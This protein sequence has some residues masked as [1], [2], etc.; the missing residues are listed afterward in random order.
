M[1]GYNM[2][3]TLENIRTI[4][5]VFL[6]IFLMWLVVYYAIKLVRSNFRTI[7]IFK[8]ILLVIIIDGIAKLLGL[9]TIAYMTDI[10]INWGFLAVII[11]F[12]PEIRSLLERLGKSNVFSRITTLTGNEKEHLVDQIVTAAMLLSQDQTG[13]LI[14]IEQ[15]HSLEDFIA[16]GTRL[17]SDVTAELLTSIFVTSTPLHDGAV[18]IQG[19]KIAC[20][21][22]YFPPTN[23]DL[24]SRYGARH[25]AAIGISEITDAVTIVISEETGAISIA[26]AGKIF[27]VDRKQLRDYLMR[28]ILGAETEVRASADRPS[29]RKEANGSDVLIVK[30]K[31]ETARKEERPRFLNKLAVKRQSGESGKIRAEEV[32]APKRETESSGEKK[33]FTLFRQEPKAPAEQTSQNEAAMKQIEQEAREIKLPRKKQRSAPSYPEYAAGN[34]F[35]EHPSELTQ[36]DPAVT[37][38]QPSE[39]AAE[40]EQPV[41]RMSPEEVAR[42]RAAYK[43]Q[44]SSAARGEMP[45][46]AEET[47]KRRMP[48]GEEGAAKVLIDKDSYEEASRIYDTSKLDISR[49]VGL[50]DDLDK[51][52]EMLDQIKPTSDNE[53]GRKR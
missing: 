39:P 48:D 5:I 32:I 20:A 42:A 33:H 37:S 3:L 11:I 44:F 7:Q 41:R 53:G 49:I 38:V 12:Q 28:T 21:S 47:G 35:E 8:G 24:S 45:Q 29:E 30:E 25:R 40:P 23:L 18:I 26:E 19:D 14:T 6:D 50:N 34:R 13:A 2:W 51:T 17:N 52:F 10:F 36:A 9:K 15:S 16:T 43:A 31:A 46:P 4:S 27:A 22:A 1:S